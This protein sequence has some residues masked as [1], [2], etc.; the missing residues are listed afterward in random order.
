MAEAVRK[1]MGQRLTGWFSRLDD[2]Q[3]LRVAF[4][5]LLAGTI[6][7]IG[8][9]WYER[10]QTELPVY[11][12]VTAPIPP[13]V[14]RPEIDPDNPAYNPGE[15]LTEPAENL[16]EP[17]RIEL[18][19]GGRLELEGVIQP[20]SADRMAEELRAR[21]E[22]VT[23]IALNSPG[24]VVEEA[25]A[26]GRM[27][28]EGGYNTSVAS[29][30]LCASSCPLVLAGGVERLVETGA[31]VGVHQIYTGQVTADQSA[32]ALSDAQ[33][34]TARIVRYLDEM[35]IGQQMWVHALETPPARLYYF[36]A[37]EMLEYELATLPE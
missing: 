11:D 37:D 25:L 2:G 13:S 1:T 14:E 4:Y 22:Y 31:A 23:T 21:G 15:R 7:V 16:R 20:G 12:P 18:G 27:I 9:D 24:G 35:G 3:I 6:A 8:V 30:A 33:A 32:Q 28:R 19:S 34:T 17:L 29:G 10:Q 26:M 36:T 5:L